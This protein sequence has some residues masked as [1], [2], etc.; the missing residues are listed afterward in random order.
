MASAKRKAI[1]LET[2]LAAFKDLDDGMKQTEVSKKYGFS[3]STLA[4]FLKKRK[5]IESNV[6][7]G[8]FD[9][10]RKRLKTAV[11]DDVDSATIKWFNEMRAQ[12][13]PIGGPL[14]CQKALH[15]ASLL[16]DSNFKASNGWLQRFK[17]RHGI[18]FKVAAGEE[19]SAPVG[20]ADSWRE[21]KMK[22]ILEKY[23]PKDI[24]NADETGLFYQ[25][26]PEKTM[27][28]KGE[29]CKGGKQS[30]MRLTVMLCTNATGTEKLTPLVIGRSERP[31]CFKNVKI[32]PGKKK[33][34][35]K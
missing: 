1:S 32:L 31:R 4:T 25:M 19:K 23:S 30:K 6:T 10:A 33:L 12:N 11:S 8:K 14:I 28:Y 24:F 7:S 2:K 9:P 21:N 27:A 22:S 20:D 3:Q 17:D 5:E 34:K 13:V 29:K 26:M 35:F 16:G 18:V 15:F